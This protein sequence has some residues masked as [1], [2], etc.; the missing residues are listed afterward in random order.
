MFWAKSQCWKYIFFVIFYDVV[1]LQVDVPETAQYWLGFDYLS[2]DESV[3][4]VGLAMTVDGEYPYYE[5]R[6]L[7]LETTWIGDGEKSVDRYGNEIVT[8]PDKLI[9]WE[10]KY[11]S[12]SSYRRSR[13]LTLELE[14]GS[15]EIRLTVNEGNFLLGGLVLT[16]PEQIPEYT[17][18]QK[19]EGG[20]LI[21]IQGEDFTYRN[22]S[23]IHGIAEYDTSLYPYEI[24]DTVLNTIDSD[25][26][27]SA[28]QTVPFLPAYS[29]TVSCKAYSWSA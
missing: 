15:H 18:S 8:V 21:E 2:Y 20:E 10:R 17:G 9:Q 7:E 13:P 23:A 16:A 29:F 14:A 26:F 24:K 1:T 28:G 22:D 5:C 19:A 27:V 3:L 4:P 25:S 11:L 6:N 12:D